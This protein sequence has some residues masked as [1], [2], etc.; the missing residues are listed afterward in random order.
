MGLC[1]AEWTGLDVIGI[2][3]SLVTDVKTTETARLFTGL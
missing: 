3:L 1:D 2:L